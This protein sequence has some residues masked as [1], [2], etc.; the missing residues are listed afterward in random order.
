MTPK[1]FS[2]LTGGLAAT[3]FMA[4]V[5]LFSSCESIYE[6]L[7]PCPQ[8]L[9]LRFVYDYNM[10]FAN[11]FPSQVECLTVL[12]YDS[13]GNY[14]TTRTNNTSDLADENWRMTIDLEPD[15]YQIIAYGGMEC[16]QSSFHFVADPFSITYRDIEVALNQSA[17]TSPVGTSLHPLFY[18]NISV[19][20]EE[21]DTDYREATV[22]MMKD[23]NNLRV[24]LQQV[25]GEPLDNELYDFKVTDNNTL[26]AYNND[27]I[28][29][30]PV[31]YLPWTRGNV[32]PGELPDGSGSQVCFAEMSFP[33]LVTGNE[34]RLQISRKSDGHQVIDIPLNNYLLLL[35]S[36]QF[37]KMGAQEYLDRESRWNMIFF[38]DRNL[39]WIKTQIVINDWV[40]RL[41]NTDL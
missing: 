36:E 8:G 41:N 3:A 28:P 6:D 22:K 10:E 23:T 38:L 30:K 32:S 33:R 14:V 27:I 17:L 40:V 11:A 39:M 37:A 26:F 1:F 29:Q 7:D 24:V 9:R 18:G 19:A 15:E 20:V 16:E 25:D 12:F 2:R 5:S 13:D 35:K 4:G 31:E 34:P 21:T